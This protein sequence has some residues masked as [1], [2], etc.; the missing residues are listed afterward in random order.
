MVRENQYFSDINQLRDP[1]DVPA[2]RGWCQVW[3][4]KM[5]DSS[6]QCQ[7]F[8]YFLPSFTHWDI[9]NNTHPPSYHHHKASFDPSLLPL[10]L[11]LGSFST[12]LMEWNETERKE[13]ILLVF[14]LY[15]LN[16]FISRSSIFNSWKKKNAEKLQ[17][18]LSFTLTQNCHHFITFS[19]KTHRKKKN[20]SELVRRGKIHTF[21]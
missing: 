2:L 19:R 1:G 12:K 13:E 21:L 11:L 8:L 18:F 9:E 6:G 17:R 7:F 4:S 5:P 20:Q 16:F 14:R 10:N 3:Y 15:L